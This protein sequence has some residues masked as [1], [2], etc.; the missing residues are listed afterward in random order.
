MYRIRLQYLSGPRAGQIEVHQL[1]RL[2]QLSLGRDPGC[3][4][5]VCFS[6]RIAVSLLRLG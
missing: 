2:A 5:E 4:V 1:S 6:G 3:D